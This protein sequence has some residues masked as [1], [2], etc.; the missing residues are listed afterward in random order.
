MIVVPDNKKRTKGYKEYM[1]RGTN[2]DRDL[3]DE[4][5]P[6]YGDIELYA[7]DIE[8]YASTGADEV[9]RNFVLSFEED[10][11]PLSHYEEI[12]KSFIEQATKGYK[13]SEIS[14]HAELHYPKIKTKI[15]PKTG[16]T[17]VRKPHIHVSILKKSFE[18]DVVLD[19][20]HNGDSKNK[21]GGR[22]KEFN[23]WRDFIE[24]KYGLKS[25][26]RKARSKDVSELFPES[27]T[28]KNRKEIVSEL[29]YIINNNLEKSKNLDELISNIKDNFFDISIDKKGKETLIDIEK[30][31]KSDNAKTPYISIKFNNKITE[32]SD[33]IR[34]KGELFGDK[35]FQKSKEKELDTVEKKNKI[36]EQKLGKKQDIQ[37]PKA[38]QEMNLKREEYINNRTKTARERAEKNNQNLFKEMEKSLKIPIPKLPKKDRKRER[39]RKAKIKTFEE[40]RKQ[41]RDKLK[42]KKRQNRVSKSNPIAYR[43][44]QL[45]Q[46]EQIKNAS[47]DRIK[48]EL[49][50]KYLLEKLQEQYKLDLDQY[51]YWKNDKGEQRI[52]VGSR[53]L[54]T[55]DFL[56]KELSI[57]WNEAKKILEDTYL[58]YTNEKIKQIPGSELNMVSAN[59]KTYQQK[60]FNDIYGKDTD[61][62]YK[63]YF[64]KKNEDKSVV[65]ANKTKAITILDKGSNIASYSK[66]GN[67]HQEEV[68]VMLEIAKAKGW[69]LKTLEVNGSDEFKAEVER[70]IG[71]EP[72]E[73]EI[74]RVSSL[75]DTT[76]PIKEP[77]AKTESQEKPK[78][79]K[80][81]KTKSKGR[82]R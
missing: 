61:K 24:E 51:K 2:G 64:I 34:L 69:D 49:D 68:S 59:K 1:E 42:Q 82:E 58:Q 5:V 40:K 20:G 53:N 48:K 67:D 28:L 4:R 39:N 70:Q 56:T 65:L 78:E 50:G 55:T 35:T 18:L 9:Y 45:R 30:I 66:V 81:T 72:K 25:M 26:D 47:M 22:Q 12:A 11:M 6:L 71:R 17:L 75:D 27:K 43:I 80:A 13:L 31:T 8:L 54:N 74:K 63:G 76:K 79:K 37:M 73:K 3:K 15:D 62:G 29:E 32:K 19:L 16:E 23:L 57:E 36:I 46:N 33:T 10:Y 21:S 7:N 44:K 38:L 41:Y 52:K 77:E 14:A 60:L